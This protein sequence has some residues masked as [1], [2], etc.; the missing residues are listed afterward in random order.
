M[1]WQLG[2]TSNLWSGRCAPMD[3]YDI[4]ESKLWPFERSSLND[5]YEYA[6]RFLGLEPWKFVDQISGVNSQQAEWFDLVND[7]KWVA[8]KFQWNQPCF[9]ARPFLEALSNENENFWILLNSRA[10]AINSKSCRGNITHIEVATN[11]DT[12]FN[13]RARCCFSLWRDRD[14]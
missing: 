1:S 8:T 11:K 2:G 10:I 12:R 3:Q 9:N 13:I 6:S 5:H 4:S 7:D 14:T